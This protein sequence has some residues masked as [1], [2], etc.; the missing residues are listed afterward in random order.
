[1]KTVKIAHPTLGTFYQVTFTEQELRACTSLMRIVS[2]GFLN[3]LAR[4]G[5]TVQT[6]Q[7]H[8]YREAERLVEELE[9]PLVA[10][11]AKQAA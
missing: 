7:I 4:K 8:F 1:M 11:Q 3:W 2:T 9:R 10:D 6:Q 5:K